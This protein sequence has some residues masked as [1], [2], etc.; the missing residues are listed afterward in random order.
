MKILIIGDVTGPAGL[1]H[2][3]KNLWRICSENQTDFVIVN[4]ENASFITGI[5]PDSAEELFLAG[6]D[7]ITGGN[8]TMQ[9]KLCY[10]YLDEKEN[11]L[12]PINFPDE[13]CGH[14]Y[15]I[16]EA[17]NGYRVLVI[18]A[19]GTVHMEPQLNSPYSYIDRTLS[20]NQGSYDV[21]VID[22]H[23]EATGEKGALAYNYDG[24]VSVVFGTHTHVPTADARILPNGT[25][26]I[27]DVG[28][29]GESEG[30]LGMDPES[31]IER[32]KTKLP[33]KFKAASGAPVANAILFT[34]DEQSG[35]TIEAKRFDF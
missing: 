8:H 25:G 26:Y 16:A 30:I 1:E 2:L 14:G 4:A 27:T 29:C 34:V 10:S 33:A 35:K 19:L 12:R 11:I 28:M 6:A 17:K 23:A 24:R 18:S 15:C 20:E 9:N 13:A 32:M 7:V 5:S 22:F 3:K 21:S 31:V